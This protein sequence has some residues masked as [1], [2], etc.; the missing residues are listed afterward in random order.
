MRSR[1]LK[2]AAANAVVIGIIY[3]F[4]RSAFV[5]LALPVS[6]FVCHRYIKKE[7]ERKSKEYLGLQF[8]DMLNAL[9]AA[10]RAGYS[11]ENGL[12]EAL[13]EM[14][15]THGNDSEICIALT[16]MINSLKMGENAEKVFFD[17]ANDS[18]VEDIYNFAS[19]FSIAK[20]SGGDMVEIMRKTAADITQKM[21]TRAEISVLISAKRFEQN[22]MMLMPAG[23]IVYMELTSDGLLDPLYGNITGIIIMT[24]C[25]GLYA[26]AW[27][28][29]TKIINIEV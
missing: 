13:G 1:F 21:E 5:L 10:M 12:K 7:H 2:E 3:L 17:F 22:I 19:I 23:I 16:K 25:L 29:S 11:V 9:T 28:L 27:F 24:A 15:I 18:G 20:R 4:Y 6:V 8:K 26:L 14:R